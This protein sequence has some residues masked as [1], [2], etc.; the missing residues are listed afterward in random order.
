MRIMAD[1]LPIVCIFG[2]K[3]IELLSGEKCP[4]FETKHLDCR[5]YFTD[6][7]LQHILAKDRPNV[8][9]SFG[10]MEDFPNLNNSSFAVRKRWLHYRNTENLNKIGPQVFNCFLHNSLT[11]RNDFPLVSVFYSDV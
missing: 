8:V 5:C 11:I 2:V 1:F 4:D 10:D 3:N 9:V 6:E 7:N